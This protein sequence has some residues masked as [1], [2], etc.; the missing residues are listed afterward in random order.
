MSLFDIIK[1]DIKNKKYQSTNN[2]YIIITKKQIYKS[3]LI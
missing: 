1:A 3:Q 2:S